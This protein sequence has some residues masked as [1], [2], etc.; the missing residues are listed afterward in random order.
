MVEEGSQ[1]MRLERSRPLN[2]IGSEAEALPGCP[3]APN[4][5][6]MSVEAPDKIIRTMLN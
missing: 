1:G 6:F 4:F 5:V 2:T 3:K